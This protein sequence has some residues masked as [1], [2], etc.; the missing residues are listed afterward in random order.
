MQKKLT[1]L[2]SI[3]TNLIHTIFRWPGSIDIMVFVT[4][5][6]L[7][8]KTLSPSVY[9][10]DSAELTT[11]VYTLGIVHNTGYPL[12]LMLAKLFT[13]IIPFGDIAYRVNMFSALCASLCLVITRRVALIISGSSSA[14]ILATAMLGVSYPLWSVSVVA[15]VYTLHILFL[16]AILWLATRWRAGAGD[17]YLIALGLT[18]GLSF[19]N[20]MATIL[21]I[22]GIAFFIW[23]TL[24]H[25]KATITRPRTWII[26]GAAFLIGLLT[27]LYLPVRYF[28]DPTFNFAKG[29]GLDLSTVGGVLAF[30]RGAT[31]EKVFFGYALLEIP[32]QILIFFALI[33]ETFLGIGLILALIGIKELWIRDR[34]T[35]IFLGIIFVSVAVFY[36]N[37]RVFDKNTMFLPVFL[38]LSMW[39]SAGIRGILDRVTADKLKL[40]VGWGSVGLIILMVILNFPRV[41]L[42]DNWITRNFAE[43]VFREVPPESLIIG[44]WVDLTPL[45]YLREV[46]GQRPDVILFD[47]SVYSLR[48]EVELHA[49]G[50][51]MVAT[52][53]I[54]KNEIYQVVEDHLARGQHAFSLGENPMFEAA[55]DQE[56][57]SDWLYA[58]TPAKGYDRLRPP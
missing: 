41:D 21:N 54:T 23:D 7:Y 20:H 50:F 5:F 10:F 32:E 56:P 14:S 26:T 1:T 2:T 27:Y 39:I 30:M 37:Y 48:R 4:T 43:D 55:F 53:Y 58:I 57:F 46:E 9:T 52:W 31:L 15:E 45:A 38:V 17:K 35:T 25:G 49:D 51:S 40:A 8:L 12:Y 19:G 3:L 11:G 16:S 13:L 24:K 29:V 28:A 6:G 42:S 44:H 36:I 22:P 34:S 33:W 47:Y 18:L